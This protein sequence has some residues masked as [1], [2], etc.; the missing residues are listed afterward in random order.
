MRRA[1]PSLRPGNFGRRLLPDRVWRL[2]LSDVCIS[3]SFF[4]RVVRVLALVNLG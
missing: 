4:D 3:I 1:N 2:V